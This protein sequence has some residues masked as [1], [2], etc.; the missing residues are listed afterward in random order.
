MRFQL[1]GA[2]YVQSSRGFQFGQTGGY[3][4]IEFSKQRGNFPGMPIVSVGAVRGS[5]FDLFRRRH[6]YFPFPGNDFS[7]DISSLI[8]RHQSASK[9]ITD[10]L[11][12]RHFVS[13]VI[14]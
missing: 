11:R 8:A 13:P 7:G 4:R 6:D 14:F 9:I 12:L 3:I 2:L 10:I 5:E 1:V